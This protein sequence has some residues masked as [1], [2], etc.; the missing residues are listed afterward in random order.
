MVASSNP[1]SDVNKSVSGV[2]QGHAYTVLWSILFG[3]VLIIA[4]IMATPDLKAAAASGWSSFNNLFIAA[5]LPTFFG[6]VML[7][8]VLLSNFLCALAA[9]TSTSRMVYA[10]ARDDGLPLLR[11]PRQKAMRR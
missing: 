6:K 3:F 5:I 8:G 2:V 1:G 11:S 4:M 7:I 9:L 10:F